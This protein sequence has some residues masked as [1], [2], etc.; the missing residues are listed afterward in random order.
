[1]F[2]YKQNPKLRILPNK[3]KAA[4]SSAAISFAVPDSRYNLL[5]PD[6]VPSYTWI[7]TN[8][9]ND[10]LFWTEYE[11]TPL[12]DP[13]SDQEK[14]KDEFMWSEYKMNYFNVPWSDAN[15]WFDEFLWTEL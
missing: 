13:W 2:R 14:W 3:I 8:I 4:R 5:P 15:S 6:P 1:M 10:S 7:D 12:Q 9:W 11:F